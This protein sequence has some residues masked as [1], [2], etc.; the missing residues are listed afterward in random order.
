[1]GLSFSEI[2]KHLKV[3]DGI[4]FCRDSFTQGCIYEG[5]HSCRDS[6]TKGFFHKG[7]LSQRNSF[8]KGFIHEGIHSCKDSFKQGLNFES[9]N[10]E[11]ICFEGIISESHLGQSLGHIKNFFDDCHP[12][13]ITTFLFGLQNGFHD[14]KTFCCFL[15]R[16]N[17]WTFQCL[18]LK[19]HNYHKRHIGQYKPSKQSKS[20]KCTVK[21]ELPWHLVYFWRENLNILNILGG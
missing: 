5:I 11:G 2:H 15:H 1:M 16:M 10:F 17:V 6:F 18:V 19:C 7:I 14:N 20:H 21:L 4:H 8:T 9:I 3:S 12:C 13:I